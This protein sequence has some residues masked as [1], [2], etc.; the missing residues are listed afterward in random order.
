MNEDLRDIPPP[1]LDFP[2]PDED[3]PPPAIQYA[4]P[5]P[6]T[7]PQPQ[8]PINAVDLI[9]LVMLAI[10]VFILFRGEKK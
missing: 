6:A 1:N 10:I 5:I 7:K 2:M 9:A 8:T 3:M 4:I